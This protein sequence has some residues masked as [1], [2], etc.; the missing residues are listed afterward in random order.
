MST[1]KTQ[2]DHGAAEHFVQDRLHIP[3]LTLEPIADGETAQAYYFDTP[4]GPRVL[5]VNSKDD[6]GFHKDRFAQTHFGSD[7]VPIPRIFDIGEI[8]SGLFYAVSERA[9]GKTL[10][11]FNKAEIDSLMPKI[12]TTLDAIHAIPPIGEGYGNWDL[13]GKGQSSSWREQLE[14]DLQ[15]DDDET[16]SADF[17]DATLTDSLRTEIT[18][19]LDG[20][21]EERKLVHWDYGFNNT[22][23][24]GTSI[25]GVIDW[26]H[27]AYG[28]FLHDVAWLDFWDEKQGYA[29]AFKKF[30]ADQGRDVPRFDERLTC[31]KLLIGVG[32]LG[33][34]ARSRQLEKYENAKGI[35]ARIER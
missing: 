4:E 32:S 10:D 6:S 9:P 34:F 11:K 8:E 13:H 7:T 23:S 24:D 16:T 33:F 35:I 28:D 26:E 21:P 29:E 20:L 15:E 3:N 14:K 1:N 31:Y 12:I 18:G 25:T 5:R 17:Y 22:L 27:A 2:I 30:Y 19:M